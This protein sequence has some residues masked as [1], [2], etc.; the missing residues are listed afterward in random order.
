MSYNIAEYFGVLTY[1]DPLIF[2]KYENY[3]DPRHREFVVRRDN[4]MHK[5]ICDLDANILQELPIFVPDILGSKEEMDEGEVKPD[6]SI[7]NE[8]IATEKDENVVEEWMHEKWSQLLVKV[9]DAVRTH[10]WCIVSLYNQPPYWRVFTY[11]EVLE[12]AYDPITEEPVSAKIQWKKRLPL[13]KVYL[14]HKETINFVREK[15]GE[16][17]ADGNYKGLACFISWGTDIDEYNETGD[18][19]D[20][21]TL[22]VYMRYAMLDIVNNSSKSSGFFYLKYLSTLSDA[23]KAGIEA[24]F[25]KANTRNMVG[26]SNTLVEDVK[27]MYMPNPDF[28]ILAL[29]K[30]LKVYSGACGMPLLYFNGEKESGSLFDQSSEEPVINR[31]KREIFGH[32]K[33]AILKLVEIRWGI[34]CEDV[35]PNIEEEEEETFVEEEVEPKLGD[36]K[37]DNKK[38]DKKKE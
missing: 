5:Y 23:E 33:Q 34:K 13:S 6:E 30:M 28:P 25:E 11:R 10:K 22:A 19:E 4:F 18:L 16:L 37:T 7:E 1:F 32:F 31:K 3:N 12:I 29:D 20:K 24:S 8:S 15:S 9:F 38:E 2:G 36:D 35:F 14:T 21:W 17:N 27:A 26:I